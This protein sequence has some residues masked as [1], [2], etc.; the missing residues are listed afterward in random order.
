MKTTISIFFALLCANAIAQQQVTYDGPV[1]LNGTVAILPATDIMYGKEVPTKF[2]ALRLDADLITVSDGAV[3]DQQPEKTRVVQLVVTDSSSYQSIKGLK[4]R[5]ATVLCSDI[6]SAIT[7]HHFAPI[8]CTVKRLEVAKG[9]SDNHSMPYYDPDKMCEH[10]NNFGGH[11]SQMM[12]QQCMQNEQDAYD[13]IKLRIASLPSQ[14]IST[15]QHVTE[16]GGF[17]SYAMLDECLKNESHSQ[18]NNSS[19][20]FNR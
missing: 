11:P 20:Q 4:G 10:L 18:E 3:P 13:A 6:S 19:F 5:H 16:F 14:S 2:L 1:T 15:C 17:P 7:A 8:L 12:F 9:T